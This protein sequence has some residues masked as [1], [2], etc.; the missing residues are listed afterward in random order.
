MPS[1]E[2]MSPDACRLK[3]PAFKPS[4]CTGGLCFPQEIPIEP[5]TMIHRLIAYL[6][7][8]FALTNHFGM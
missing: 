6:Q 4:Y 1:I 2:L 7:E 8:Q 5:R 3:Y